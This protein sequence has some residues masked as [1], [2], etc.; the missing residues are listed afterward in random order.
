MV[1]RRVNKSEINPVNHLEPLQNDAEHIPQYLEDAQTDPEI[2]P[3]LA[4]KSVFLPQTVRALLAGVSK[5]S[6]WLI[7]G[8]VS[9]SLAGVVTL[10]AYWTLTRVPPSTNCSAMP[11]LV[12]DRQVLQCAQEA[13]QSGELSALLSGL[14]LLGEWT[15]EDPLYD[16]AQAWLQK[17]SESVLAIAHQQSKAGYVQ[18]AIELVVQIPESSPTYAAAQAVLTDWRQ[19]G[20]QIEVITAD[21]H[22]AMKQ[23]D[24][25]LASEQ[26]A[27]LNALSNAPGRSQRV[28]VL[29]QQLA[30]EKQ[31]RRQ[32]AKARKLAQTGDLQ[33]LRAA[34]EQMG[35][36]NPETDAWADIQTE[37]NQWGE[38]LFDIGAAQWG[39]GNS[40][41]AL[42]IAE[43]I[44][45]IQSVSQEARH[46]MRL[47]QADILVI[48]A[49]D[50]LHP[51]PIHLFNLM[52]AVA[53]VRQIS[54]D[55]QFYSQAQGNLQNWQRQLQDIAHLQIAQLSASLGAPTSFNLAIGLAAQIAP[56]RPQ[57]WQAQTLIDHWRHEIERL[58][59][60]PYLLRAQNLAEPGT[61]P[62]LQAAIA[63]AGKV[64][65]GRPARKDAQAMIYDWNQEI[66]TIEDQPVLT[67]AQMLARQGK[68]LSAIQTAAE[69]QS[70]RALHP[71]AQAA[72]Q[73]WRR[74]VANR[75][76]AR[77]QARQKR[78]NTRNNA[79]NRGN[80]NRNRA[81]QS[82]VVETTPVGNPSGGG[83]A[84]P[85]AAGG[86]TPTLDSLLQSLPANA[87]PPSLPAILLPSAPPPPAS[88]SP[89]PTATPPS[90]D[91]TSPSN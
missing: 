21:V 60:R 39:Q 36:I 44:V 82:P 83:T 27:A 48:A 35:Q 15:D 79:A 14:T 54:P 6:P 41:E 17:W 72:I 24:W 12:S 55:S 46:L 66:E 58:D 90:D 76:G 3:Q 73:D 23:Q 16:E 71:Q 52:E 80:R 18:R 10:F 78:A 57:R 2:I 49:T 33:Q 42:G 8:M 75:Q 64:L 50:S 37:L 65:L 88:P 32:I 89:T 77:R 56:D 69:I 40:E 53:A 45:F 1:Q 70:G 61:I 59:D 20:D 67:Q 7:M 43:Q 29:L 26:I 38:T 84:V 5:S 30:D 87:S 25:A 91:L 19:A 22:E 28:T 47:S 81:V 85:S 51:S 74:Q 4:S 9:C 62:A 31:G 34:V 63:E 68:L 11:S 86:A 13:A